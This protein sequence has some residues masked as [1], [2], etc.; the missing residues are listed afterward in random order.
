MRHDL[1]TW[2]SYFEAVADGQK[3]FEIRH[4][5]RNFAVGDTLRLREWTDVKKYTGRELERTV[6][7]IMIGGKFGLEP[8]YVVM[9]LQEP[10]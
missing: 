8:G 4:A 3:T 7:Y 9:A 2:P 5:D 1:K 6:T 10:K